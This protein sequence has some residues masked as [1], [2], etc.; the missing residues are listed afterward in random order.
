MYVIFFT[1]IISNCVIIL[2]HKTMYDYINNI[3]RAISGI[4]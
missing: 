4:N 2:R 1:K 3:M